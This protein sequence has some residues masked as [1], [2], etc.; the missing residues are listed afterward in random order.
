MNRIEMGG[1][2]KDVIMHHLKGLGMF[3]IIAEQSKDPKATAMWDG[4]TFVIETSMTKE[5]LV[6][7]FSDE[8]APMPAVSPW[9]KDSP[10]Y[11]PESLKAILDSDDVRFNTYK[12]TIKEAMEVID[13]VHKGYKDAVLGSDRDSKKI[14]SE[15]KKVLG[16]K[17]EY[18]ISQL[19]NRLPEE[20]L[21]WLDAV[22][23]VTPSGMA[24]G[25]ILGSGGNDG[26]SEISKTFAGHVVEIVRGGSGKKDADSV[27]LL[28]N[29]L[30]G[31]S[32]ELQR[33]GVVHFNPGA[34]S[35]TATNSTGSK[36]YSISNPWDFVLAVEG[37]VF[38]AG[39]VQ[40]RG[41]RKFAAFPFTVNSTWA[42]HDT[43][44]EKENDDRGEV[45]MPVWDRPATYDEVRYMYSEGRVR[46]GMSD[47]STGVEFA[48]ALANLGSMRGINEFQR[49]GIF[50][51]KGDVHHIVNT[52]TL[53]IGNDDGGA[54]V[55]RNLDAWLGRMR[56]KRLPKMA[57]S[58]LRMVDDAIIRFC[59]NREPSRLQDVLVAVGRLEARIALMANKSY[60]PLGPL[61]LE[62]IKKSMTD[63]PEFRLAASLAS[64]TD[65]RSYPIRVNLEPI[66]IQRDGSLRWKSNSTATVGGG[67]DLQRIMVSVLERRCMRVD[68]GND[69]V[70][71]VPL[72]AKLH[73]PIKDVLD[74]IDGKVNDQKIRDLLLPM[75]CIKYDNNHRFWDDK[76]TPHAIPE[77]YTSLKSNFPPIRP[78]EKDTRRVFESSII[79]LIKSGQTDQATHVARRRLQIYGYPQMMGQQSPRS[80][81]T[82]RM[83]QERLLAS[84]LFPVQESTLVKKIIRKKDV[85]E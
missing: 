7:F 11:Q 2:K 10:F 22:A 46:A 68:A 26:R 73:A 66:E 75:S 62:W 74:F 35:P 45:W 20:A 67:K 25:P 24:G 55:L 43:A 5:R 13:S 28:R 30:F 72:H 42:G 82:D 69:K 4:S 41:N 40:R 44:C 64:V 19:C 14:I 65:N 48:M 52:G 70:F 29:S 80:Y 36:T 9:N 38:F 84:L 79:R 58:D 33:I 6:E 12:K 76:S 78:K 85:R 81:R 57:A 54:H 60:P 17:K 51:R 53:R 31:E 34:Y 32:A 15:C 23:V 1:C 61:S 77:Q 27:A 71:S 8:Y 63:T 18:I 37:A 49:F 21:P 16:E 3:K 56:N 47:P 50:K 59:M 39:S 83:S